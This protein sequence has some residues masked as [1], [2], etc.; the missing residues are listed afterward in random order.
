MN[1]EQ[2]FATLEV[3]L[4]T[5]H[6]IHLPNSGGGYFQPYFW[7]AELAQFTPLN[8][9]KHEQWMTETD[10]ELAIESWQWSEQTGLAAKGMLEVDHLCEDDDA[11]IF[12]DEAT[13]KERSGK[14]ENLLHLLKTKLENLKAY[15]L[16]CRSGYELSLI[17]GQLPDQRWICLAPTV[18]Q[19]T[20]EYISE[21]VKCS[22]CIVLE[23]VDR[24]E[25][26]TQIQQQLDSLPEIKVYGWYEGGYNRTHPY[27][28]IAASGDTCENAVEHALVAA[29][30]LQVYQFE[31]FN[32]EGLKE[33]YDQYEAEQ[34]D[35]LKHLNRFLKQAFLAIKLYRFCFWDYE[36]LYFLGNSSTDD[37]AGF[38]LHSQFEYNP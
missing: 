15:C 34:L 25:V 28:I 18:P 12:L 22:P 29:G 11:N 17:V 21:K 16:S 1:T 27:K 14:Y 26:A 5:P 35:R 6:Y 20:R 31:S 37:Q 13:K 4:E 3:L 8:L 30:M 9:L 36:H 23:T 24:S 2:L 32:L 19:E 33:D 10:P 38:A 7:D